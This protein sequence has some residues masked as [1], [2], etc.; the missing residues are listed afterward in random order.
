MR[1]VGAAYRRPTGIVG[2]LRPTVEGL[3]AG[4][5]A[6]A[7]GAVRFQ[8]HVLSTGDFLA[9]WA[10]EL[11]VHNLDLTRELAL[12]QPTAASLRLCRTTIEALLDARLPE[13]WSDT[14]CVLLGFGRERADALQRQSG[15]AVL[16]RL[17]VLG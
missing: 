9:T 8:G 16:D 6:L 2:H 15:T 10:V 12:P 3:A 7:P 17:P 4:V 14:T 1:L 13:E 11:A 5:S